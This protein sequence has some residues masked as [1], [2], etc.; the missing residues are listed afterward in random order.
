MCDP[1]LGAPG[2]FGQQGG[3]VQS[4]AG[5]PQPGRS[6]GVLGSGRSVLTV[7]GEGAQTGRTRHSQGRGLREARGGRQG[8]AAEQPGTSGRPRGQGLRVPSE[9]RTLS[10]TPSPN[11]CLEMPGAHRL[12]SRI[13]PGSDGSTRGQQAVVPDA[14]VESLTPDSACTDSLGLAVTSHRSCAPLLP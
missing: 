7:W 1:V 6:P 3:A 10:E 12:C 8:V 14:P 2:A 13:T 9:S 4:W 5:Q 11:P